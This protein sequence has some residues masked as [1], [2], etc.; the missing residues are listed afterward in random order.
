VTE[1]IASR[2][3]R[4]VAAMRSA[5]RAAAGPTVGLR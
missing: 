4:N 2:K 5:V 3:N 1:M